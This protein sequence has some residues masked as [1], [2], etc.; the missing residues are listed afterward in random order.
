MRK[1]VQSFSHAGLSVDQA[2][3]AR[4]AAMSGDYNPIHLDAEFASKTPFGRVIAHGSLSLNLV[5]EA[6]EDTFGPFDVSALV[7]DVRFK[8]PVFAGDVVVAGG[9]LIEATKSEIIYDVWVRNQDEAEIIVG[10]ATLSP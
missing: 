5:C 1:I 7:L 6:I 9:R 4:Y 10:T 3:I 8:A 2:T